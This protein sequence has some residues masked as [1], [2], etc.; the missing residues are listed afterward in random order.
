MTK[1]ITVRNLVC[2]CTGVPRRDLELAFNAS[3]LTP[4]KVIESLKEFQ[5]STA[6]GEAFQY[7][8]QMVAVGGHYHV[9]VIALDAEGNPQPAVIKVPVLSPYVR[10]LA[11][12]PKFD[13]LYVGVEV[14]K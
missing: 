8:N 3:E 12:S 6:F 11:Y 9:F 7:S 2:A 13:R 1:T 14:S 4:E 5:V 10:A